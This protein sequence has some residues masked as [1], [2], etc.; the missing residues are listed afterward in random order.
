MILKKNFIQC[1]FYQIEATVRDARVNLLSL[2]EVYQHKEGLKHS[3]Q[4]SSEDTVNVDS[5]ADSIS[6]VGED[7]G[8]PVTSERPLK[9]DL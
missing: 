4:S 3:T 6:G 5:E 2:I 9:T 7:G 1:P 8:T